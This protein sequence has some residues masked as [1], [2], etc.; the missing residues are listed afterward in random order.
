MKTIYLLFAVLFCTLLLPP[1]VSAQKP[2]NKKIHII[3]YNIWNG[4]EGDTLRRTRFVSWMRQQQPDIVA[5]EELVGFKA[6]H[7]AELGKAY[8]HPYTAIVKEEGYP[9][10]ITSRYP[11]QVVSRQIK[12][13]WHGML[14]AKTGGLN[15]IVTHLSPFEWKYRLEETQKVTDYIRNN[16][17]DS[18]VVMGDLNAYSPFDADEV[19][20]HKTL[21]NNMQKWD[22]SQKTYRNMRREQFDYSVLSGFLSIGMADACKLH[23]PAAQRMSYPTAFLYGWQHDDQRLPDLRERLDY[24]LISP[25]L[26]PHCTDAAVYNGKELEGIS[27]HYPVGTTLS[28]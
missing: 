7:L 19:E 2:V 24:I 23:V 25:S 28:F 18:C 5:L 8:G 21:R 10:G 22:A 11:I 1:N 9:V 26:V 4:F 15:V 3:S 20:T 6:Q 13:F 17:L 14:H 27:D 16:Q 12:G